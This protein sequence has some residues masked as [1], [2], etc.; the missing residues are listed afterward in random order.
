MPWMLPKR[1]QKRE[2]YHNSK[3]KLYHKQYNLTLQSLSSWTIK[4][5]TCKWFIQLWKMQIHKM[6]L[7]WIFSYWYHLTIKQK[8]VWGCSRI[9]VST[10]ERRPASKAWRNL[11]CNAS[12]TAFTSFSG[13]AKHTECSLLAYTNIV[14]DY[15]NFL[16]INMDQPEKQKKIIN[17]PEI[18]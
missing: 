10:W 2:K 18:S 12:A 4:S 13:T 14:D 17:A 6:I 1:Q 8:H 16:Y 3:G 15:R 7:W 9:G 5:M 11:D